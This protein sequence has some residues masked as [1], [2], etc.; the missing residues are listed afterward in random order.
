MSIVFMQLLF[1]F[2]IG[3]IIV[4]AVYGLSKLAGWL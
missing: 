2:I 1:V 4:G 3:C